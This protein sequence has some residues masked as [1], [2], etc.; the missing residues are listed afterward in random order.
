MIYSGHKK[1]N[2]KNTPLSNSKRVNQDTNME[3]QLSPNSVIPP[4]LMMNVAAI[5][6]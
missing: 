2:H 6:F 4:L 3:S 1:K 5:V